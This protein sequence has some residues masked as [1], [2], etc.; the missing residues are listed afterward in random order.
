[1]SAPPPFDDSRIKDNPDKTL[2]RKIKEYFATFTSSNYDE[3]KAHQTEDYTMTDIRKIVHTFPVFCLDISLTCRSSPAL[4]VVNVNREIWY[5]INKAFVQGVTDTSVTAISLYGSSEPGSFAVMENLVSF[6]LTSDPP[7]GAAD[8]LP[9]GAKAG[10]TV[11]M[12]M[13]SVLWWNEEEKIVR[14]L[15]YGR[16][17]WPGFS[18]DVFDKPK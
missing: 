18:L 2:L 9:P 10:D 15:E 4:C 7:P 17:T 11:K 8:N 14:E 6:K 5:N 1:M 12:I 16:L 3:M 13:L